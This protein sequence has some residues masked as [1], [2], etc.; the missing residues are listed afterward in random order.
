MGPFTASEKKATAWQPTFP[1]TAARS[2]SKSIRNANALPL[3][4]GSHTAAQHIPRLNYGRGAELRA[5]FFCLKPGWL[6]RVITDLFNILD[7]VRLALPRPPNLEW[8]YQWV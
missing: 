6:R 8:Q 1:S 7:S 4:G 2:K 5:R 3:A